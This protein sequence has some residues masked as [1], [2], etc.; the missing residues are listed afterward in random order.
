MPAVFARCRARAGRAVESSLVV[1]VTV[2]APLVGI[3]TVAGVD[4]P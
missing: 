2:A 1:T 4:G 3:V